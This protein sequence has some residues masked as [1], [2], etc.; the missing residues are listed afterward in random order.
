MDGRLAF[1]VVKRPW[2]TFSVIA[3]LLTLKDY[4]PD[5]NYL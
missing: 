1:L 2:V 5:F 4:D 3:S